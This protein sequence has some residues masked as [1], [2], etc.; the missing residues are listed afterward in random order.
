MKEGLSDSQTYGVIK[1]VFG[2]WN[3]DGKATLADLEVAVT[4]R[5]KR[6]LDSLTKRRKR[7]S[8]TRRPTIQHR[9][10][11]Q[12]AQPFQQWIAPQWI[13]EQQ[14]LIGK[15][16]KEGLCGSQVYEVIKDV[17][18]A[19]NKGGRVDVY[20][21]EAAFTRRLKR[22]LDALR[23]RRSQ[24]DSH[25]DDSDVDAQLT[26]DSFNAF[27]SKKFIEDSTTPLPT[28]Q[29]L[30]G[31]V[32]ETI[33]FT[34]LNVA[35]VI[36]RFCQPHNPGPDGVPAFKY[37]EVTEALLS[38]AV[39]RTDIRAPYNLVAAVATM[40]DNLV[41]KLVK[42]LQKLGL[43]QPSAPLPEKL[44]R[45]ADFSRWEARLKDYLRGWILRRKAEP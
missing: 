43:Q 25:L 1:E 20:E 31:A 26:A 10:L 39:F 37:I 41:G 42:E 21:L 2:I 27:L 12:G 40:S 22:S 38:W 36:R 28:I 5:L 17:Y 24:P 3:G 33:T 14:R 19:W 8:T 11:P 6:S 9:V 34:L 29:E 45:G 23:K 13:N 44:S 35:V 15:K 16:T 32:P 30:P 18:T 7:I 4:K